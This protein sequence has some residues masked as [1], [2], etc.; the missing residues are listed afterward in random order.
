MPAFLGHT[1]F[2]SQLATG[3]QILRE[4]EN[5]LNKYL[6][7]ADKGWSYSLGVGRDA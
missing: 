1:V 3:F 6:R 5:I 2:K 4:S 7:T